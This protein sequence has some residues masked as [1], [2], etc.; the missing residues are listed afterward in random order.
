MRT[1]LGRPDMLCLAIV[2]LVFF[3]MLVV[4]VVKNALWQRPGDIKRCEKSW[5][6]FFLTHGLLLLLL[7]QVIST[8]ELRTDW[9]WRS[10]LSVI[11]FLLV[12]YLALLNGWFRNWL[13]GLFI[14]MEKRA[15]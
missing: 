3:S 2:H 6:R 14:R 10:L 12:S 7:F 13:M 15:E 4:A 1:V 8:T 5:G 9:N 11:D